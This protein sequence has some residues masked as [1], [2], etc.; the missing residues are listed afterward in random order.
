MNDNIRAFA[1]QVEDRLNN[2]YKA[3]NYSKKFG[4]QGI[5][6][7]NMDDDE[8][9]KSVM[10]A[11]SAG[12]KLSTFEKVL[13]KDNNRLNRMQKQAQNYL[14]KETGAYT[15]EISKMSSSSRLSSASLPDL[16]GKGR[17]GGALVPL[18]GIGSNR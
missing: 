14:E 1:G 18:S 9:T 13:N 6:T 5:S 2:A 10:S 4:F 16:T 8:E 3:G 7:K 12:G 11:R 15:G 17:I